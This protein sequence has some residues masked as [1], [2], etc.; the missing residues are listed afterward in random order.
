MFGRQPRLPI[1]IA[2]GIGKNDEKEVCYDDFVSSLRDRMQYA[3]KLASTASQN[4]QTDNKRRYDLRARAAVLDVGDRVLL[5]N[6]AL[7]GKSKLANYWLPDVY[8][9]VSQP[10]ANIPVY[11]VKREDGQGKLKS[12]HRNLMLP[13]GS[14]P[15]STTDS[16]MGKPI[17]PRLRRK[18]GLPVCGPVE[19][20]SDSDS[21]DSSSDEEIRVV[22]DSG[23]ARG[24]PRRPVPARRR[25]ISVDTSSVSA[26]D[27]NSPSGRTEAMDQVPSF[28]E[29]QATRFDG[30]VSVEQSEVS[31]SEQQFR[32]VGDISVS[33]E[34]SEVSDSE[35]Q[36]GE[37]RYV[38][39]PSSVPNPI[40]SPRHRRSLRKQQ[41]VAYPD[42]LAWKVNLYKSVLN[43]IL[44]D[45]D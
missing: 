30:V 7:K 15:M 32:E 28:P 20:E 38:S 24:P 21:E 33:V 1:D 45:S 16:V 6:V 37:V 40:P 23:N 26:V 12:L 18:S 19:A 27:S 39:V 31:D 8:V 13:I 41:P 42:R 29:F 3:Y 43:A 11:S 9:V 4:S 14:V 5:R 2:F 25:S 36:S 17:E 10:N 34:Q 35:H 22:R 44:D